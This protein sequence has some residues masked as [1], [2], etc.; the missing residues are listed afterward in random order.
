MNITSQQRAEILVALKVRT[1]DELVTSGM[2]KEE[3]APW[4]FDLNGAASLLRAL[5]P[6]DYVFKDVT[7]D[8]HWAD[9]VLAQFDESVQKEFKDYA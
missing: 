7:L 6:D 4:Y 9:A 8:K 2:T 5:F 1:L 3:R